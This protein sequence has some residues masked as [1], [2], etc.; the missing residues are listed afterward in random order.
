MR[1]SNARLDCTSQMESHK[2][3]SLN[4]DPFLCTVEILTT[5]ATGKKLKRCLRPLLEGIDPTF[6]IIRIYAAKDYLSRSSSLL[7]KKTMKPKNNGNEDGHRKYSTRAVA[8]KDDHAVKSSHDYGAYG[9]KLAHNGQRRNKVKNCHKIKE[10]T[11]KGD[12]RVNDEHRVKYKGQRI[13]SVKHDHRVKIDHNMVDG[14]HRGVHN[15]KI[16]AKANHGYQNYHKALAQT[17]KDFP[18]TESWIEEYIQSS[19][20]VCALSGCEKCHSVGGLE[21]RGQVL[22]EKYF[23]D[24]VIQDKWD[25]AANTDQN[26]I[27]MDKADQNAIS[28]DKADQN[29]IS[30]D[31]A[32][33]NMISMD[34]ADQNAISMDK[35]DQNVISMDKADQN[36]ISMDKADQNAI[37]MDKADQNAIS[38]DKTDQNVITVGK[39]TDQNVITMDRLDQNVMSVDKMDKSGQNV[40]TPYLSICLFLQDMPSLTSDCLS[41]SEDWA[42][43]HKTASKFISCQEFYSL[44]LY[45]HIAKT[46]RNDKSYKSTEN[47]ASNLNYEDTS[48]PKHNARERKDAMR[49]QTGNT[50]ICDVKKQD[51]SDVIHDARIMNDQSQ[52][53]DQ[54]QGQSL[55]QSQSQSPNQNLSESLN[56]NHIL[57]LNLRQSPKQCANQ[58]QSPSSCQS[59]I[60]SP[61]RNQSQSQN[62]KKY[63]FQGQNQNINQNQNKANEEYE[64]QRHSQKTESSPG[65]IPSDHILIQN[66]NICVTE[67]QDRNVNAYNPDSE[68]NTS[69][70]DSQNNTELTLMSVSEAGNQH[71]GTHQKLGHSLVSVGEVSA[72][73]EQLRSHQNIRFPLELDSHVHTK[74]ECF[75]TSQNHVESRQSNAGLPLVSV[76]Q[77]QVGNEQIITPGNEHLRFTVFTTSQRLNQMVRF[78]ETLLTRNVVCMKPDLH[79]FELYTQPGLDFQLALICCDTIEPIT[80]TN[81]FLRIR[82]DEKLWFGICE[83]LQLEILEVLSTTS[84]IVL[85]PDEN[86]LIV[87]LV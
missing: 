17:T 4:S 27:S 66:H 24:D 72:T 77:I 13:Q 62:Y 83:E 56:E 44:Q 59:Q 2:M 43:S 53:L 9:G 82:V 41:K 47:E 80:L 31:K 14:P 76:N 29:A 39:T 87:D 12:Q 85:D 60:N 20:I 21:F 75:T 8:I 25:T 69:F 86:R 52:S 78:Y 19:P 35:A 38:M 68:A 5:N 61:N 3:V 49:C 16:K 22:N 50:N 42:F 1:K 81:V 15:L 32:H 7:G 54:S 46:D 64:Y 33:Q 73:N 45:P 71:I 84:C 57:S 48:I 58:N 28:M 18:L 63:G 11:D 34:K 51:C 40:T 10:N 37:S 65:A 6:Q 36:A 74:N 55:N 30:M 26:A 23:T 67:D 70:N 79:V